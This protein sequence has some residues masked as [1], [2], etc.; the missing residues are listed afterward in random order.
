MNLV[1]F[2]Y[3]NEV[4]FGPR[5]SLYCSES[6]KEDPLQQLQCHICFSSIEREES[7]HSVF[8]CGPLRFVVERG[9]ELMAITS[10]V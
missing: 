3:N 2:V 10:S 5:G 1:F 6:I 7:S 9:V 8:F 4:G